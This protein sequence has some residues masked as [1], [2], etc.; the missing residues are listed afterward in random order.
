M[1]RGN[2]TRICR[3]KLNHRNKFMMDSLPGLALRQRPTGVAYGGEHSQDTVE[4][5]IHVHNVA[6]LH[7]M[8]LLTYLMEKCRYCKNCQLR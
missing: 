5:K 7:H 2:I 6:V 4:I 3:T 1:E 8:L